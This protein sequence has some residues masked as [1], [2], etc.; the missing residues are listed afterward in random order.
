[1]DAQHRKMCESCTY[2]SQVKDVLKYG[3][4]L[5]F[6]GP[7]V[8]ASVAERVE[9]V[10]MYGGQFLILCEGA[11][12]R[13]DAMQAG[14]AKQ[15]LGASASTDLRGPLA[16]ATCGWAQSLSSKVKEMSIVALAKVTWKCRVS[17]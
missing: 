8:A 17:A 15:V 6:P 10:I 9:P 14:W 16:V 2:S 13:L 5:G 4:L 3:W 11:T 7:V 1:M 12:K